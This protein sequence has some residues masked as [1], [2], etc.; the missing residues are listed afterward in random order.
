[1]NRALRKRIV[2]W[3]AWTLGLTLLFVKVA[4]IDLANF[5]PVSSD[6]VWIMSAS[7]KLATEG[8]FGSDIYAGFFNADQHY[9]I[10]L[11]VHHV[12]QAI[13]FRLAGAGVAQARWVSL[14][15]AID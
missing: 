12:R 7:Y 5:R 4:A 15:A 1:M 8:V 6:D 10:A 3:A 2:I 11:P 9:F 13:V 14:G